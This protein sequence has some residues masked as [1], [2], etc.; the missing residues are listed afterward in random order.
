MSAEEKYPI[1]DYRHSPDFPHDWAIH[2]LPR[3]LRLGCDY[4]PRHLWFDTREEAVKFR[5]E[6]L[7]GRDD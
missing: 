7:R 4:D 6:F 5:D 1:H 2:D 3:G